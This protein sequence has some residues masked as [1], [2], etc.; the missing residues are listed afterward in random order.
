ST[1]MKILYIITK[2]TIGGAQTHISQLSSSLLSEGE[3][4]AV[5]AH[6]GGW[7]EKDIKNKNG[8]FYPN[9]H[10]RNSYN[11]I[12]LLK[13]IKTAQDAIKDFQPD[14]ISTHSSFA[15]L[16]GRLAARNSNAQ[17][18]F[19]AH[20]WGFSKGTP[21]LRKKVI[22]ISEKLAARYTD[23][24]ICVSNFDK[25]LARKNGIAE[26]KKLTTI[27]N[28]TEIPDI[29]HDQFPIKDKIKIVSVT[30][31]SKQKDPILLLKSLDA[32]PEKLKD[33]LELTLIGAG[34]KEDEVKQYVQN[35]SIKDKIKLTG[36]IS[37]E[38]VFQY[39]KKSH[40][41][42]LITKWEGFPRSILEAMS[43]GLPVI[44]TN[45]AGIPESV[46]RDCGILVEK[47]SKEDVKNAFQEL[48]SNPKKIEQKGKNARK[49]CK[50]KFS[51]EKTIRET[52][53]IYKNL[54]KNK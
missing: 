42:T 33:K 16:V 53:E 40:I 11:P 50:N 25:K 15:G 27:H 7:L 32:L 18:L 14:I 36:D 3:N 24:I 30:R 21:F 4:V 28:G 43:C 39:L 52:K 22:K 5:S 41:F 38:K 48:L 37:R 17:V 31:F 8:K 6:P 20:G 19:T 29:N 51:I 12:T 44:A 47:G 49:R 10:L 46:T 23:K 9:K 54:L 34:P 45:T 35:S 26:K 2:S 1:S 13:A